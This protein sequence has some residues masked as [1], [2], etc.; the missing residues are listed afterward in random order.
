MTRCDYS[1]SNPSCVA[2]VAAIVER[3]AFKAVES[4][5]A[6]FGT[7]VACSGNLAFRME[8]LAHLTF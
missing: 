5:T 7:L 2:T 8:I 3:A 1:L 6:C 4:F